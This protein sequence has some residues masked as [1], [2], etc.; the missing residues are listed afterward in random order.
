MKYLAIILFTF[1]FIIGCNK[2][3]RIITVQG[4]INDPTFNSAGSNVT[5]ILKAAKIE[6]GVYNSNYVQIATSKSDANGNFSFEIPV[7]KVSGYRII[8]EK[9]NYFDIEED[10]TTEIFEKEETYNADYKIFPIGTIRLEIKNTSPQSMDDEIKYKF[11][12]IDQ[13]CKTCCNN[14]VST[15]SGPD[16]SIISECNARGNKMLKLTWVITKNGNQNIHS[17]SVWLE[18]FKTT[19]YKINY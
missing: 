3:E 15:G 9:E 10:I 5:V 7:E 4:N 13:S 11:D 6:S 2:N 19:T 14:N 17:D 12:N 18:A 8:L 1:L 16:F